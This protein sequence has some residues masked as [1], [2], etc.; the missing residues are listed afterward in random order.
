MKE[1]GIEPAR[2]RKYILR[3]RETF[4]KSGGEVGLEEQKRG[5]K[6]DGGERRRK[7][8]RA[9]KNAKARKERREE[10]AKQKM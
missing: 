5:R 4:R 1:L 9:T 3:W 10:M 8:V 7:D 6:I 2:T